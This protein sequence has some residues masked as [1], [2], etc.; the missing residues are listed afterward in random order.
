LKKIRIRALVVDDFEPFRRVIVEVLQNGPDVFVVG[1][2]ADGLQAVRQARTLQP[3]LIVLDIGLPK[4]NGIEAA[5]RIRDT[6]PQA[7]ILFVSQECSR[8]F[9]NEAFRLGAWGYIH[10]SALRRELSDA[11]AALLR[12]EKFI[13]S[14]FA[15]DG[16][17]QTSESRTS[18]SARG[19]VARDRCHEV[20]IYPDDSFFLDGFIQFIQ[21]ALDVG[22]P[23]AGPV[24]GT[25]L[26]GTGPLPNPPWLSGISTH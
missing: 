18:A 3:Y 26:V 4:L 21:A 9:V 23:E 19:I 1:E 15:R 11:I 22:N 17:T 12:G 2:A 6:A 7:K 14:M 20:A 5:R 13:G 16:L 24:I 25:V 8:D 10:K